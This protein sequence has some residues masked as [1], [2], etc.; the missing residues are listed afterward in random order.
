MSCCC[1]RHVESSLE[2][3]KK[4][5]FAPAPAPPP[6]LLVAVRPSC[7]MAAALDL[8]DAFGTTPSQRAT[9]PHA[10]SSSAPR[11]QARSAAALRVAATDCYS[12]AWDCSL[13]ISDLDDLVSS[14]LPPIPRAQALASD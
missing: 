1:G 12:L 14:P 4:N 5:N 2:E 6:P 10:P 3:E 11:T 7:G 13:S 8:E 9:Q